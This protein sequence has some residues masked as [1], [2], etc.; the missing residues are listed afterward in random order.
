MRDADSL[1]QS[2][3]GVL[4]C[5]LLCLTTSATSHAHI[6]LYDIHMLEDG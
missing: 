5:A 3:H 6:Y 4:S 1:R 2:V